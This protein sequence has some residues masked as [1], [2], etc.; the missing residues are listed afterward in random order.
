MNDPVFRH[1]CEALLDQGR[2]A[3]AAETGI[4]SRIH[5]DL[6]TVVAVRARTNVFRHGDTFPLQ[7]TYCRDV[8]SRGELIALTEVDGT[9]GLQKH[10]LYMPMA[11]EAYIAAPIMIDGSVWGTVNYT[12]MKIREQPFSDEDARLVSAQ[13]DR[14]ASQLLAMKR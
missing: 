11:L 1:F 7:E 14:I 4:V 3:L 13:A 9:P 12:S 10:P 5:D 6:Y 8:F 2:D